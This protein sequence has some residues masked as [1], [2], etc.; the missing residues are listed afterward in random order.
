MKQVSPCFG[1]WIL[2][3][4]TPITAVPQST[5]R[6][7]TH[8]Q[9]ELRELEQAIRISPHDGAL[10]LERAELLFEMGAWRAASEGYQ[11]AR[12]FLRGQK[13]ATALTYF[14]DGICQYMQGRFLSAEILSSQSI[15]EMPEAPH[16]WYIRGKIRLLYLDKKEDGIR[17]LRESLFWPNGVLHKPS[18]PDIW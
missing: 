1:V 6:I 3:M 12:R 8:T 17:D 18:L 2:L 11:N 7:S 16:A 14:K 4:M 15:Q 13:S 9:R 10:H 5:D